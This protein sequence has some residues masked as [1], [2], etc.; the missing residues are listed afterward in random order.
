MIFIIRPNQCE[1]MRSTLFVSPYGVLFIMQK[2]VMYMA[3]T[4]Q[5][6]IKGYDDLVKEING[7]QAKSKKVVQRT[8]AD[9]KSR[10]PGWVSQEVAKEYNIKKKDINE[11]KKGVKNAGTIKVRG[12]KIDDLSI[13][14]Q[15]R[16]LT[17]THFG[18]TP[19]ARPESG[20][21]YTV[22]AKIK[23][24]GGKKALGHKVFLANSGKP[25]SIQIPFQRRDEDR[26][27]I[28]VV[29]TLSV[30]QMITNEKVS[31]AIHDRINTELGK[32]LEHHLSRM[33][34]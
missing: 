28:D 20:K 32:R 27:P 5:V 26:Y 21:K 8:I 15:G 18:M 10:G 9:F 12:T 29:K 2:K 7:M 31:T 11:A 25:G 16:L 33:K 30:P 19:K 24:T 22:Q 3:G 4:M 6:V 14:Y 13:V 17:P 34:K 23:K 1:I